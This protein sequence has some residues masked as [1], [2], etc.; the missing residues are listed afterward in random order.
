MFGNQSPFHYA[1]SV[2]EIFCSLALGASVYLL[3]A[4]GLTFPKK[5]VAR[6]NER[7]VTELSMTPSSFVHLVNAGALGPGCLPELKCC[8][9]SGE[10]MPWQ[11]LREWMQAAPAADFWHFYGSTEAFC[12]A[13]GKVDRDLV[14]RPGERL[15]VGRPFPMTHILFLDAEGREAAPGQPGEM[16]ISSPW[17]SSGYYRDRE[18]SAE[19]WVNDPLGRG[20]HERFFRT[21][22]LG[23]MREDGQLTVLGRQDHQIKHF[24]YRMDLGDVEA[25]LRAVPQVRESCALHQAESGRIFCFYAGDLDEKALKKALKALLAAYMLPDVYVRLPEIPH[26][27]NMK[28]DRASLKRRMQEQP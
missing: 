22:D 1:N 2:L 3:P 10:S 26:T 21:G 9:M 18:R 8:V 27:P 13:A 7:R 16:Y 12:V 17:V 5:F 20:W 28:I 14:Y 24:G 11:P 15:P 23:Y 4:W 19:S 6:L 25:A